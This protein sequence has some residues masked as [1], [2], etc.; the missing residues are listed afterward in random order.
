MI[1]HI[2]SNALI[3]IS[4]DPATPPQPSK[5]DLEDKAPRSFQIFWVNDR[6]LQEEWQ[7]QIFPSM[8]T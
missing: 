6:Y 7:V 1:S 2:S 5:K 4:E 8:E 3:R